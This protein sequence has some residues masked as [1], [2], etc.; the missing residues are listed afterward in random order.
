MSADEPRVLVAVVAGLVVLISICLVILAVVVHR[1]LRHAGRLTPRSYDNFA[2][3]DPPAPGSYAPFDVGG[4]WRGRG[5]STDFCV[6]PARRA[7]T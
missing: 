2:I 5:D 4:A 7:R 1:R 6:A 3:P